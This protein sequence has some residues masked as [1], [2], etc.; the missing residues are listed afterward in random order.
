[1]RVVLSLAV[2]AACFLAVVDGACDNACSGHGD[3][4]YKDV[5]TCWQEWKMGDEDGGDCSDRKC[6]SELA[7]VDNP[8]QN[9]LHHRYAECAGRGVCDRTT[10]ECSCFDG[11][12]GKACQRTTCPND[13]S[14]HGRCE[15]IEDLPYATVW[16][17]YFDGTSNLKGF[18][19]RPVTFSADRYWDKHKTRGCVCDPRWTD[20][21]CSRRMCP[22]GTDVL[23]H[24]DTAV[25]TANHQV[26]TIVFDTNQNW[27]QTFFYNITSFD[28]L[29]FALQFTSTLNETYVTHPIRVP[30]PARIPA[31]LDDEIKQALLQLPH[32][33]VDDV[34]VEVTFVNQEYEIEDWEDDISSFDNV[35]AFPAFT[36]NFTVAIRF[37]G[38]Y[39][40]GPQH[41]V[42]VVDYACGDG[43]TPKLSGLPLNSVYH[44]SYL[45]ETIASA[46]NNYEC[47][48]RGKCDY[49]TGLCQCFDGYTGEACGTQTA[50]I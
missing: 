23:Q 30:F 2:V 46:Y 11:F 32:Q 8:D 12:T 35:N 13:C 24:K 37:T 29:T 21:D 34:D 49:D 9:G 36:R 28:H 45:R 48:R 14:G 22:R 39:V 5:C 16:G 7:W 26:Q 40:Q 38:D 10:G 20:V 18:G 44:L 3:C 15:Y 19:D 47:G 4:N 25:K 27:N 41:L 50:L 31:R 6:P 43:C 17:D 33:V 1:M 42:S